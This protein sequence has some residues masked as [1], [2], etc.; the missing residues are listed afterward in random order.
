MLVVL[1]VGPAAALAARRLRRGSRRLLIVPAVA[2]SWPLALAT[3][4]ARRASR[5]CRC[6][7]WHL[8]PGSAVAS[9]L[10]LARPRRCGGRRWRS[11]AWSLAHFGVAV[12]LFGMAC[13]SAFTH[14]E[15]GRGAHRATPSPSGRGRSRSQAVEPVAGPNWTALEATLAGALRRA[16]R[17][18]SLQPAGAHLLD[19]GRSRPAKSALLTRWNG[20]LYAVLGEEAEGG[21]WQ[22][23]L[24]WKPFVTLIWLRRPADRAGRAAGAARA[25]ACG[26]LRRR[27]ARNKIAWRRAEAAA[28]SA[29]ATKRGRWALWLPLALFAGFVALVARRPVPA[30]RSTTSKAR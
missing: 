26:D 11:G 25:R 29:T 27:I 14:R 4:L 22:L 17:P 28:M 8:P 5:C 1:A 18:R 7:A 2:G 10:P 23:R 12:A 15:A 19:A 24:W 9:L 21:R 3:G 30:R 20:Q 6:S 16:A 13:E